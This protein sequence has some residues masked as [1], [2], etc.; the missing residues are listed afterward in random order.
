M[1]GIQLLVDIKT[2]YTTINRV[3]HTKQSLLADISFFLLCISEHLL[4][5][6]SKYQRWSEK[7]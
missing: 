4:E 5:N 3:S 6:V 1:S 7:L 2:K